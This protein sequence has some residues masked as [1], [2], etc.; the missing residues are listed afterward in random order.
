MNYT[1]K[2]SSIIR[3][4][5]SSLVIGIDPDI[6]K[7]P[8]FFLK[9]KNPVTHFGNLIIDCTKDIVAGYKLNSA[10]YEVLEEKGIEAMK[11]NLKAIPEDVVRIC[12]AKRSDIEN[13]AEMYARLFFD[14]LNFDSITLNPYMGED[15]VSSFIK[16]E[17]KFAYLLAATSN[18]GS[19]DFQ[20]LIADGKPFFEW[21]VEKSRGWKN[22]KNIGYVFG[23][24]HTARLRDFTTKYPAV[25]LLIPG[26]GAQSNDLKLLIENLNSDIFVINSSRAIIYSADRNC[27]EDEFSKAVRNSAIKLNEE[28]SGFKLQVQ[29]NSTSL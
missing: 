29:S 25:P 28:I 15:S 24:N 6:E 8:L 21:I 10:F 27:T 18:S 19:K 17:G 20:N 16:R 1:D 23:A 3:K 9:E 12:D 11:N 26:I 13:S 4:N 2:L 22:S 5:K 14:K 7:L